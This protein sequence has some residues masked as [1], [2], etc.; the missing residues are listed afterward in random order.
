MT[1]PA[2]FRVM[3]SGAFTAA[4]LA[5][6]PRLASVI[7]TRVVTAS[8]S[9]G[10]G[11][12]SLPNRLKRGEVVDIVIVSDAVLQQFVEQGYVLAEGVTVL[13]RS[14]IAMAVR[15]GA[16]KPDIG[17]ADALRNTM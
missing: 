8:T 17:S 7:G 14:I 6:M 5:L 11:E 3:T 16:A 1:A 12:S 13:A 15:A 9:I 4:H 10:T 2:E